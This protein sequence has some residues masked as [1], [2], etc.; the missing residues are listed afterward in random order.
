MLKP[1]LEQQAFKQLRFAVMS[2]LV[3]L[4]CSLASVGVGGIQGIGRAHVRAANSSHEPAVHRVPIASNDHVLAIL[5]L[6]CC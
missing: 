4:V 1:P 2:D 3:D 5:A 6:Q